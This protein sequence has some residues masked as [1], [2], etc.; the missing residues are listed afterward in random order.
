MRQVIAR[1]SVVAFAAA[2]TGA[3]V[4]AFSV[5][6]RGFSLDA[7]TDAT[8]D[9]AADATTVEADATTGAALSSRLPLA[10]TGET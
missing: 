2:T 8:T 4:V 5:V 7:T 3:L 10:T 1:R 9:G 6:A